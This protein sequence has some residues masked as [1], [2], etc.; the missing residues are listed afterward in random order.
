M[1]IFPEAAV[2][3]SQTSQENLNAPKGMWEKTLA[4]TSGT[5]K[6]TQAVLIAFI[7]LFTFN[8]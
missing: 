1:L 2:M 8:L 5:Q 3:I 7:Y 6:E 4:D